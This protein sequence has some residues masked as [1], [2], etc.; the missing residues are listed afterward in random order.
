MKTKSSDL[1]FIETP[2]KEDNSFSISADIDNLAN[3]FYERK[4]KASDAISCQNPP[5]HQE[6]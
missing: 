4:K 2:S 3:I 1:H 5:P 6:T